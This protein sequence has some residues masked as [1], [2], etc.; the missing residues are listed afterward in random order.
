[1]D[2][3][4]HYIVV[5]LGDHPTLRRDGD[6]TNWWRVPG[7]DFK[8]AKEAADRAR[9]RVSDLCRADRGG[10]YAGTTFTPIRL[11][12]FDRIVHDRSEWDRLVSGGRDEDEADELD[13]ER[14]VMQIAE[15][16]ILL[17]TTDWKGGGR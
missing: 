6:R 11:A 4:A 3:Q 10:E 1:M 16:G 2:E 7:D 9:K 17:N 12:D 5:G 13:D 14:I 8:T 15:A